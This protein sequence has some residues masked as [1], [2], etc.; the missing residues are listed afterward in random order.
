[1]GI[2][3][4]ADGFFK[5]LPT[6]DPHRLVK[7]QVWLIGHTKRACSV[8]DTPVKFPERVV[9]TLQANGKSDRVGIQTHAEEGRF[10]EDIGNEYFPQHIT[11]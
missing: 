11:S 2:P 3:D 7:G 5:K 6:A 1:M 8:N 4:I 9:T 10:F